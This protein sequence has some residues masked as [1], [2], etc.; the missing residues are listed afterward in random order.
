MTSSPPA[1]LA[2]IEIALNAVRPARVVILSGTN[3]GTIPALHC[4]CCRIGAECAL[5]DA[6]HRATVSGTETSGAGTEFSLEDCDLYLV[7]GELSREPVGGALPRIADSRKIAFES[8][9]AR[10]APHLGPRFSTTR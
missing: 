3:P 4:V 6:S 10:L 1:I 9:L 7:N 5:V 2:G 8:L